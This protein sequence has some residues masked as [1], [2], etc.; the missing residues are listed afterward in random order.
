CPRPHCGHPGARGV[1]KGY[2]YGLSI[3]PSTRWR[4]TGSTPAPGSRSAAF[5]KPTGLPYPRS[6]RRP[7]IWKACGCRL[8]SQ[9]CLKRQSL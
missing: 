3:R 5:P 8:G 1:R 9:S 6:R 4:R 2:P 7:S